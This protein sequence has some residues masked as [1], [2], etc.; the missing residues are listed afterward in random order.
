MLLDQVSGSPNDLRFQDRIA[1]AIVKC[2]NR[3]SPGA[4][5]GNAPIG[6]RLD[7]AFDA[8]LAPIRHPLHL[9]DGPHS[10]VTKTFVIDLDEPLIHRSK[11]DGRLAPPAMRITVG[12]VLLVGE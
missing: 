2:G 11:D 9:S 7:G 10:G 12:I 4:L 3:N 5:A 1:V 8:V 6:P